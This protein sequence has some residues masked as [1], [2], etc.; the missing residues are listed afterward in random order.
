MSYFSSVFGDSVKHQFINREI[1]AGSKSH[2]THHPHWIFEKSHIW[3][4]DTTNQAGVEVFQAANVV[5]DSRGGNVVE[6]SIHGKVSPESVFFRRTKR[7]IATDDSVC[8]LVLFCL[9]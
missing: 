2:G 7:V 6:K 9:R 5:D 4:T 1:Q 3:I 8:G